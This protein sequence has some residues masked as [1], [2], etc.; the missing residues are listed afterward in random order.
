MALQNTVNDSIASQLLSQ[1]LILYISNSLTIQPAVAA[2]SSLHWIGCCL[3]Q[4][5]T[6]LDGTGTF[7]YPFLNW[8]TGLEEEN[9]VSLKVVAFETLTVYS[10]TL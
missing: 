2:T 1:I 10:L 9:V 4:A 8:T 5:Y 6:T 7:D 3:H